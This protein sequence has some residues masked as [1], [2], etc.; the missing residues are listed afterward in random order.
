MS[1]QLNIE[2][3][4]GD[5]PDPLTRIIVVCE[6]RRYQVVSLSYD[7]FHGPD[8][9]RVELVVDGD[10]R[11]VDRLGA[12]LSNLVGVLTVTAGPQTVGVGDR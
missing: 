6:R 11:S 2:L 10:G 3:A 7:R 5:H 1:E 8:R 12:W 4:T 9:G